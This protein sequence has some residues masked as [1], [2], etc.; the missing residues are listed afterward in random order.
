VR[1]GELPGAPGGGKAKKA[2][3]ASF[4]EDTAAKMGMAARS[5][6]RQVHCAE[7]IDADLRNR[8]RHRPEIANRRRRA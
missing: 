2:K 8:I 1:Q 7:K 5:V 6:S 4:V 3:L